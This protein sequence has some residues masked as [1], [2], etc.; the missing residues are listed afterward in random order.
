M[1]G[2]GACGRARA[3]KVEFRPSHSLDSAGGQCE[4]T[5][6]TVDWH[7]LFLFRSY[8]SIPSNPLCRAMSERLFIPFDHSFDC[9]SSILSAA[10][11]RVQIRLPVGILLD[12]KRRGRY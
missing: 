1:R 9:T 6:I 11:A 8:R 4:A 2:P 3:F 7:R 10:S 5:S 12:T